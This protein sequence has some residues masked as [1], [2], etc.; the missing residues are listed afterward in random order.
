MVRRTIVLSLLLGA[1]AATPAHAGSYHV[2]GCAAAGKNWGNA[3]WTGAPVAGLAVDT[4]CAAAGSLIGLRIDGGKAIA[5]G[6]SAA[7]TFTSPSGTTIADFALDRYLDFRSNPPLANTRPLYAIY[8]LGGTGFAGAGDYNTTTRNRLHALSA[9]YGY[10]SDNAA[11]SRRVNTLS[12]FRALAGYRGT[13][14][15]LSIT[16]GCYKRVT[17]CSGPAGGRVFNVLYGTDVVVNDPVKPV[18]TV[19]AE[20][21]LAGGARQGSDPVILSATDNA[22]IRRVEL[23][24]VTVPGLAQL[25]GSEDYATTLTE[26]GALCSYR[27]ERPCPNLTREVVR[28]TSLPAGQRQLVVRTIDAAGNAVDSGP[29]A[30]DALT[31]SD[32]GAPNGI[33]ATETGQLTALFTRNGKTHRTARFDHKL[34]IAGRLLNSAGRPIAGAELRLV[35]LNDVPDARWAYRKSFTTAAD[36]TFSGTVRASASRRL[37]L[38]WR[39][40]VN[41]S[42]TS[43]VAELTLRTR[44]AARI[45]VSTHRPLLGERLVIRGRLRAPSRGVT[46]ILQGRR[47]GGGRYK[48]FADTTTSRHGRFKVGYRFRDARSRARSFT[49]RAKLRAGKR[50]PFETGYSRRVTVR[51][52]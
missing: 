18:A 21:L 8:Q 22:G 42:H 5:N 38:T 39:S 7:I 24:D 52:G 45:R 31:P 34:P 40:H 32:R 26:A 11:V 51:V 4:N 3:S 27:R 13:A 17:A 43:A 2:Y 46:V 23:Y 49:F 33:G 36:G 29:Y 19:T 20:G 16:V 30:I 35:T 41:D 48:T 47:T 9:W 15:R 1:L 12:S 50:Y 14:R 6:T 28:P 25:V 10:P 37:L 44:A